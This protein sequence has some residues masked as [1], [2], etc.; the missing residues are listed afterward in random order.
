MI[1]KGDDILI[2]KLLEIQNDLIEYCIIYI[3]IILSSTII[4]SKIYELV[5]KKIQI[6]FS[7]TAT[8]FISIISVIIG[9]VNIV[10]A[11]FALFI[12]IC[13]FLLGLENKNVKNSIN[14]SIISIGLTYCFRGISILIFG[15]IA[16]LLNYEKTNILV[17]L[18]IAVLQVVLV[19]FAMKSK[20]INS[21]LK[22]LNN[23][24][25]IGLL[26]FISGFVIVFSCL[27][28]QEKYVSFEIISILYVGICISA[29]G[30]F[31]WIR[32]SITEHYR[33]KL[34]AKA[35]E[36]YQNTLTEKEQQI[37][38]LNNSNAFLSKIVHR[39]NHIISS[40][41]HTIT[42]YKVCDNPNEREK[43]LNEILTLAQE[44]SDLIIKEQ[45]NTKVLPTTGISVIDGALSDMYIKATAHTI[46]FNL[47]INQDIHYLVNNLITQTDLETLLCDHI[48][49]AIIA[50]N[51]GV[52]IKGKILVTIT[53]ND[54]IYEISIK[55][56]GID[57]EIDTLAKL[58]LERVTTHKDTGGSG[59]GFITTIET[60]KKSNASLIITEYKTKTPFSKSIT[61]RFDG[62]NIFIINSYRADLLKQS[63]NRDDIVIM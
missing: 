37:E 27:G 13:L 26:L 14:S 38:Q 48:K 33:K 50:I 57:F 4:F 49:D 5:L 59:I 24:N 3:S 22:I 19:Y 55:D 30:L 25:N 1:H 15:I 46:D 54:D 52:D 63:I 47:I 39:D 29:I 34:Q 8:I 35:D 23:K 43:L 51:S 12:F 56:N 7:A 18:I 53:M 61:F 31:L 62:L 58:G 21:S 32:K 60:L 2:L 44:R 16:S 9:L 41:Q 11:R 45:I 10:L 20:R 40:L 42:K 17:S 28:T 36:Y 6:I